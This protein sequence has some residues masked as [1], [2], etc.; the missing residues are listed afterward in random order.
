MYIY[1]HS[2]P[3][4]DKY[5]EEEWTRKSL[6]KWKNHATK[7]T[8]NPTQPNPT[9]KLPYDAHDANIASP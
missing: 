6:V 5:Q 4:N 2:R 3:F 8:N 1:C 9:K 7:K